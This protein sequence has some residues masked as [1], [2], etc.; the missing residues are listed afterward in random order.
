MAGTTKNTNHQN[1]KIQKELLWSGP[2]VVSAQKQ[3]EKE[4]MLLSISFSWPKNWISTL[5]SITSMLVRLVLTL[6][7][8]FA[9]GEDVELTLLAV[10]DAGWRTHIPLH[11]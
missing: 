10:N 2:L 5:L 1:Q 3:R 4:K 6:P 11:T 7:L 9:A 8:I